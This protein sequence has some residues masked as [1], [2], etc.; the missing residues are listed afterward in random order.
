MNVYYITFSFILH[1][2]LIFLLCLFGGAFVI[3]SLWSLYFYFITTSKYI[4]FSAKI[5]WMSITSRFPLFY[6]IYSYFFFFFVFL[7]ELL[8]FSLCGPSSSTSSWSLFIST[9]LQAN[10]LFSAKLK[11]VSITSCFP[12]ILTLFT[13]ISSFS[14][15]SLS[16]WRS[17]C[18]FH[19]V[20]RLLLLRH[21][22]FPSQHHYKQIQV[23][24][25]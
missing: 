1:Y 17:F 6:I 15:S 18:D 11:W 8:S 23:G 19:L 2:L 3:L 4:Q 21:D 16:F 10:T 25:G 12:F 20:L 24:N 14:S 13:C 7:E 9:S 5:K 22:H